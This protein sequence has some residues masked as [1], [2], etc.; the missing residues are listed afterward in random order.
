MSFES[1]GFYVC[2]VSEVIRASYQST[3][4]YTIDGILG[5]L[6]CDLLLAAFINRTMKIRLHHLILL[7]FFLCL[8]VRSGFGK[9]VFLINISTHKE[10]SQATSS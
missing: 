4:W 10:F 6:S 1:F 5:V 7:G 2:S 9:I 8:L 3:R